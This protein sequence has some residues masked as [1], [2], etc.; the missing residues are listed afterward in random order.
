M[1]AL[2]NQIAADRDMP[3]GLIGARLLHSSVFSA[4]A[5]VQFLRTQPEVEYAEPNYLWY[6][7]DTV[8]ND[9]RFPELWALGPLSATGIGA[10]QAWDISKGSSSVSV[11]VIDTGV[12]YTHPD[13]AANI[14]SAPAAFSVTVGGLQIDCPAGTHGYNAITNSCDPLDDNDHGTHVA[15]TIAGRGNNAVGVAGVN[16]FSQ[17]VTA[18]FLPASGGGTTA[19]AIESIEFMIQLRQQFGSGLNLRVLNNSWGGGGFSQALLDAINAANANDLLFVAAAG[20][21]DSNTDFLPNYPSSYSAPN[22]VSVAATDI[23]GAK[24]SFSNYGAVTVDLG[25][26]GEKILSTT[27]AANYGLRSGTSMAAPHVAGAAAL[28]LAK[29]NLSTAALKSNLLTTGTLAGSLSGIT[30]TGRLLNVNSAIRACSASPPS[31]GGNAAYDS[32]LRVPKCPAPGVSCDSGGLLV[33]RGALFAGSVEP[34][35][36]NTLFTSCADSPYGTYRVDES[37]ERI[38]ISTLNGLPLRAGQAARLDVSAWVFND[39]TVD[40]V[41]LYRAANANAPSWTYLATLTPTAAGPYLFSAIYTLPAGS[42]Q[43]VRARIYPGLTPASCGPGI[44]VDHDD[45]AFAVGPGAFV[46]TS[47]PS[48]TTG[49]PTSRTIFWNA[50]LGATS[51]EYCRDTIANAVCDSTWTSV[52]A[53]TTATLNGLALGTTYQWQVRARNAAGTTVANGGAWWSF[54]TAGVPAA[55]G[56]VTPATGA[57]NLSTTPV[58]SWGSSAGAAWYEYCRDTV[59]NNI[60][61]GT[62]TSTGTATSV[63]SSALAIGTT[64]H[65]QVR[66][67]NAQGTTHANGAAWWSFRTSALPA[68]FGKISP[69]NLSIGHPTN[70]TLTWRASTGATSYEYCIDTIPN[71][72]CDVAWKSVGAA[73]SATVG[74]LSQATTHYWQV[75]ARNASGTTMANAN[76]FWRFTTQ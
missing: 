74:G 72:A 41:D 21:A 54:T 46:K 49:Q 33:S 3:V 34:H 75:R 18:K 52:G 29:C 23:A 5:L 10:S 66:A 1:S 53:Q 19:N 70:P 12:D 7:T 6:P 35:Q 32:V 47:P 13:L 68:A 63:T 71:G 50:S 4:D 40:R 76:A 9:P 69:A 20:N 65:W 38:K 36:P 2:A 58:L 25:A 31:P 16:W 22:I 15:G 28:V 62:W 17:I 11:G 42:L 37:I 61:D 59:N 44:F 73:R 64:Y 56:K 55:F 24:A 39:F 27:R 14:W 8:P 43:A 57:I 45:L 30:V 60:C 48:G 51:Y 26:P 67:R